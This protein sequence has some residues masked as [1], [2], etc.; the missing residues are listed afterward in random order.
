MKPPPLKHTS[1]ADSGI[2]VE[3]LVAMHM[4]SEAASAP[5][6]AQQQPQF[7]WSRMSP[8]I[9]AQSGQFSAESKLSGISTFAS[10]GASTISP[11]WIRSLMVA[12]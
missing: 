3:A 1:W 11:R 4:R 7:D 2:I 9:F 10:E 12:F 6:K 8:M 5:A